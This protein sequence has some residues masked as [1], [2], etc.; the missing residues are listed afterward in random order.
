[1][2][3]VALALGAVGLYAYE[4]MVTLARLAEYGCAAGPNYYQPP[5]SVSPAASIEDQGHGTCRPAGFLAPSSFDRYPPAVIVSPAVSES[6]LSGP[7]GR[8]AAPF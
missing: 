6:G 5:G 3:V 7:L 2:L 8:N 4:R 1:M